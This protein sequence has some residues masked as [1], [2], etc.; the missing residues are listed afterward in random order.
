MLKT[1]RYLERRTL[2]WTVSCGWFVRV[3]SLSTFSSAPFRL[4][5]SRFTVR[6]SCSD[7]SSTLPLLLLPASRFTV[8]LMIPDPQI[9]IK[10]QKRGKKF[11]SNFIFSEILSENGV[12]F[13]ELNEF[14][15][16]TFFIIRER[17]RDE[18]WN[19]VGDFFNFW[20]NCVR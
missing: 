19:R 17:G 15:Y 16:L 8:L 3:D 11:F 9:K 2:R 10:K 4:S 12:W 13:E 20:G 18:T 1:A 5:F 6:S 14:W 7:E